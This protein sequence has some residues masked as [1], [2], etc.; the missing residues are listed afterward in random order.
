ME[1]M[2]IISAV[3]SGIVFFVL[4]IKF[5]WHSEETKIEPVD[6]ASAGSPIPQT[7]QQIMTSSASLNKLQTCNEGLTDYRK[8]WIKGNSMLL[9]GIRNDDILLT[10][11]IDPTEIS[12]LSFPKA[13]VLKREGRSLEE[14]IAKGDY[15]KYKVR[16]AWA[17]LPFDEE[18]IMAKV[19]EIMQSIAFQQLRRDYPKSF[20]SNEEM[21]T[22]CRE[23]RIAKYIREYQNC[24]ME[25]DD[26]HKIIISTTLREVKGES[27]V[28][29]SI[30]PVRTVVGK[31][32]YTFHKEMK[33]TD[34]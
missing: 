27:K 11:T 10:E 26:S 3:I 2:N 31:A 30:H 5:F 14:A 16:R 22:D 4:I 6:V 15:A 13:L 21:K 1:T 34:D 19:D 33:N 17:V 7:P 23:K 24:K 20:Y 32:V 18:Q 12:K 9:C 8:F 29:F 25:S 28:F